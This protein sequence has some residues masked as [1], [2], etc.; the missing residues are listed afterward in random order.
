MPSRARRRL[1]PAADTI[2][3]GRWSYP[4]HPYVDTGDD[5]TKVFYR[6]NGDDP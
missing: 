3:G 2:S 5:L 4:L 1:P 6:V